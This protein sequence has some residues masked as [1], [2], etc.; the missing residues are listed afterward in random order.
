MNYVRAVVYWRHNGTV[1]TEGNMPVRG[2]V[3]S[4]KKFASDYSAHNNC[5]CRI[6]W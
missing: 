5:I 4:I 3:E 2:T 6:V 1:F